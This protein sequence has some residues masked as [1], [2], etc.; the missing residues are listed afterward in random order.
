M[1]ASRFPG[2]LSSSRRCRPRDGR[3]CRVFRRSLRH[4][5]LTSNSRSMPFAAPRPAARSLSLNTCGSMSNGSPKR[6]GPG[7]AGLACEAAWRVV[8]E[9][10]RRRPPMRVADRDELLSARIPESPTTSSV[11]ANCGNSTGSG[12]RSPVAT[13][14]MA[15]AAVG[16]DRGHGAG[17]PCR[18][19]R[20]ARRMRRFRCPAP[21]GRSPRRSACPPARC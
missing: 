1:G 17:L 9:P 19:L 12:S 4:R 14:R 15:W 20:H 18:P 2:L 16:G 21:F 6:L 5:N 13:T 11:A 7:R 8:P 10:P 3:R